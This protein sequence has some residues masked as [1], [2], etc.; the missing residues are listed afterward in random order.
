MGRVAFGGII[1]DVCLEYVPEVE[2]GQYVIVHAGF[3]IS[4]L[5]EV[6]A[7]RVFEALAELGDLSVLDVPTDVD[8]TGDAR[9]AGGDGGEHEVPQ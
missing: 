7:A 1:K 8:G 9:S 2:V 3:A 6:E 5:D 4:R